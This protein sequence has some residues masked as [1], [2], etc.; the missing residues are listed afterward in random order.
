MNSGAGSIGRTPAATP[1]SASSLPDIN[2]E[3]YP[4]EVVQRLL[5]EAAYFNLYSV[6][7]SSQSR[8]LTDG[9][10]PGNI[11]GF[12]ISENLRRFRVALQWAQGP[13]GLRVSNNLGEPLA[14]FDH[15][16]ILIPNDFAALP[17]KEPPPVSLDV[18]RS[19]RFVMLDGRCVFGEG[20]DGFAG[21]GT[22]TTY[23][24]LVNGQKQL[25]VAA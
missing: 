13:G 1:A 11:I 5:D 19:Q 22:G 24:T 16:W 17:G 3:T 10:A 7:E 18:S 15:R 21:F 23:P 12:K 6:P 25:L 4:F 8:P 14:R 20:N 2:T 9:T